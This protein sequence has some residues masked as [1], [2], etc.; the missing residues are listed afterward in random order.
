M[1]H[2][3]GEITRSDLKRQWRHHV[4]LLAE[5]VRGLKNSETVRSFANTLSVA[6]RQ[7]HMCRDNVEFVIFCF[8]KPE[9]A[10]TF[11]ERFGGE[12]LPT[13]SG[14]DRARRNSRCRPTG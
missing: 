14:R 1:T 5:K 7:L 12:R 3:K 10:D 6:Q 8:A 11:C 2:R 4:A 9:D 13:D